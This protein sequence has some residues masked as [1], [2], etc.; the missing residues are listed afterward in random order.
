MNRIFWTRR[1]LQDVENIYHYIAIDNP[2]IA[3]RVVTDIKKIIDNLSYHPFMG[4][5]GRREKT[6]ELV[7]TKTHYIIVYRLQS[8][9]IEIIR[10]LHDAQKYP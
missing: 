6:R 10:I 3:K 8:N 9:A 7:V 4:K 5:P 2:N 1:A